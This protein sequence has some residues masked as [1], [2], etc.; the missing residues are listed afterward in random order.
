MIFADRS[1]YEMLRRSA[2]IVSTMYDWLE[3]LA[4]QSYTFGALGIAEAV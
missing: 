3:H 2:K 4:G 1:E